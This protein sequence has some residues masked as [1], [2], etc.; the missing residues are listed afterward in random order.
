MR[1]DPPPGPGPP[2][3]RRA[4]LTH[5]RA[6]G[7]ALAVRLQATVQ[8]AGDRRQ[9]LTRL[10]SQ[11]NEPVPAR[12]LKHIVKA[13]C[14]DLAPTSTFSID[15]EDRP[16]VVEIQ[17]IDHEELT[18]ARWV[19]LS[20]LI[21]EWTRE[22][23]PELDDPAI[24][25]AAEASINGPRSSGQA[26]KVRWRRRPGPRA[27]TKAHVWFRLAQ[28]LQRNPAKGQLTAAPGHMP[29]AGSPAD[30]VLGRDIPG[31]TSLTPRRLD[32]HLEQRGKG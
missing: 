10:A 9:A 3:P 29:R 16:I 19:P 18:E 26:A 23:P 2:A 11:G 6:A 1:M 20:V 15:L 8:L 14:R 5:T 32:R 22:L 21:D 13:Q 17:V 31:F 25:S 7:P 24:R 30:S 28:I 12:T 27:G 4:R